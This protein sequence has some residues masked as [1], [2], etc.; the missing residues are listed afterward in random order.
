MLAHSLIVDRLTVINGFHKTPDSLV[1]GRVSENPSTGRS[2]H[3]EAYQHLLMEG[4][5]DHYNMLKV[6]ILTP[7]SFCISS[8]HTFWKGHVFSALM[9][10]GSYLQYLQQLRKLVVDYHMVQG[11]TKHPM[12]LSFRL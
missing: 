11:S 2:L 9:A 12:A 5:R 3:V 6:S 7:F 1:V 8:S 4:G 10:K